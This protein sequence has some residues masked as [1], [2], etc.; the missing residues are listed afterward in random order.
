MSQPRRT[1]IL[2]RADVARV[3]DMKDAVEAVTEAF[4]AQAKGTAQMPPKVYLDLPEH[5]GDFRAMPASLGDAAG[6][7]WVNSHPK[8]PER[9]DLPSVMG[10]YVLSDP[11]SAYP[12]AIL[13]ATL[14]TAL[15][16]GAAAGVA[17]KHLAIASPKTVGFVGAGVQARYLHGAH[18]AV[19]GDAFELTTVDDFFYEID[20]KMISEGGED[21]DIGANA[22]AEGGGE[23]DGSDAVQVC[24]VVSAGRLQ[25]T[26]F[27]KKDYVATY[28]AYMKQIVKHLKQTN[29]DRVD[30]FKA[31]SDA[32]WSEGSAFALLT[33]YNRVPRARRPP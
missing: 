32:R 1:R 25:E 21:I 11:A 30:A 27:G 13:D 16:T 7:K 4:A 6:V 10:V 22:S 17:S 29:P 33:A 31:V 3:A 19:F 14:L 5:D 26:N 20:G 8:N 23:E 28:K 2:T 24:N 12:A 18:Q 9:F 15:R